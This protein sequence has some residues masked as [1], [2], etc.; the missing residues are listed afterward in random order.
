VRPGEAADLQAELRALDRERPSPLDLVGGVHFA[1]FVVVDASFRSV[2]AETDPSQPCYLVFSAVY[3]RS[4]A[5]AGA[6]RRFVRSLLAGRF[7]ETADRIWGHCAGY[8]VAAGVDKR[9]G[10]LRR[11]SHPTPQTIVGYGATVEQVKQACEQVENLT[12]EALETS[13]AA[14]EP[15]PGARRPTVSLTLEHQ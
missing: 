5:R 15:G 4:G 2:T 11:H 10:Y 7:A 3:D 14:L 9:A 13:R 12:E 1:R 6:D 8:P